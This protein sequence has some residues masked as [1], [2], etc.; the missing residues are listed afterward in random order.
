MRTGTLLTPRPAPGKTL[1]AV[2]AGAVVALALPVFL[3]A[4]W[5]VKGW[6]LGAVL[7]VAAQ[8]LGLLLSRLPIGAGSLASSGVQA[9]AMMFRTIA[10]MVVLIAVAVSN[11]HLAIAGLAVYGLAYT[12]EL[13]LSL[14]AYY[15][16]ESR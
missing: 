7:W 13:A 14:L 3:I 9:F 2:A 8:G 6:A 16:S 11:A 15:G 5:S 10:V 4:G 1:P 12:C